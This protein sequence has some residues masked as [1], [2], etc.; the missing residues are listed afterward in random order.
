MQTE[1]VDNDR[2]FFF[3]FLSPTPATA[4]SDRPAADKV[5]NPFPDV[6]QGT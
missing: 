1:R 6:P 2:L 5:S 4:R 3:F